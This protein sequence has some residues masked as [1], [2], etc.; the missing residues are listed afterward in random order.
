MWRRWSRFAIGVVFLLSTGAASAQAV[1]DATRGAARTLGYD[2]VKAY[3]SGDYP[4]ANEKLD[5]AYRVL[6]V[7]SLGLWSARALVKVGRLVEASER[8]AE[9]SRLP[10]SG[11]D[12]TVQKQAQVDARAELEALAPRVPSLNMRF[13]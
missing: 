10:T 6:K 3:Q 4:V 5:K 8:Y 2:G 13:E 11:G 9:V 12:E 7:P 1:D